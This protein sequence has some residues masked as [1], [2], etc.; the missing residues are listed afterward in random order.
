MAWKYI[1]V[2]NVCLQILFTI[3]LG[4][5]LSAAGV[6]HIDHVPVL[7]KFV[8][9]VALPCL[10]VRG[11]GIGVD[12]YS[13][14]FIW[15]YIGAFIL[16]RAVSLLLAAAVMATRRYQS[17][18]RQKTSDINADNEN[19]T[20][21]AT[22]IPGELAVVWL[23][24]TWISTVILGIP[25]LT[26]V[27]ASPAEGAFYGLLA[28]ISSFIFQLPCM[29]WLFEIHTILVTVKS[30]PFALEISTADCGEWD[31]SAA[32]DSPTRL[33]TQD[34]KPSET[35]INQTTANTKGNGTQVQQHS[36]SLR[37]LLGS[38]DVWIKVVS[39]VAKNPVIWGIIGGFFISLSTLGEKY[40]RPAS[41]EF[42][43]ELGF[44][45]TTLKW[46]GDT[47]SPVSLFAMGVWMHHQGRKGLFAV[48]TSTMGL[49]MFAKLV[50][51]PFLMIGLA[52]MLE[53]DNRAGRAAVLIATLP[54]SLASFS[55]G[56]EYNIG[57]AELAANVALGTLLLLPTTLIWVAAMDDAELYVV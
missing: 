57:R 34:P 16:L 35:G 6:F 38:R 18:R 23:N 52:K 43:D 45:E 25:I 17:R 21:P 32:V 4:F 20:S 36:P 30:I 55:L 11:I 33:N 51:A 48:S 12:F 47:V 41:D 29:L 54:I 3:L 46:F 42:V 50:A 28:G 40:F 31:E 37:E 27:F 53:L 19:D 5:A 26:A 56:E 39:R 13:D 9:C 15:E 8:F 22:T 7:V 44:F 2:V 1:P 14:K 10:V 24:L 49:Y